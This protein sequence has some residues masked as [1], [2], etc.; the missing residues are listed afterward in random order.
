MPKSGPSAILAARDHT[1]SLTANPIKVRSRRKLP[2]ML[3][4]TDHRHGA[5]A[6]V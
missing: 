6:A 3:F 1:R 2:I 5:R 4:E